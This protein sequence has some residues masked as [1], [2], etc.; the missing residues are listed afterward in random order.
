MDEAAKVAGVKLGH[1]NNPANRRSWI[2]IFFLSP[3]RNCR[4]GASGKLL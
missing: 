3:A 1:T 4:L 2:G